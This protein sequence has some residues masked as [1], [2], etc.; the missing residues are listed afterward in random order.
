MVGS[1]ASGIGLALPPGLETA[2]HEPA[3]CGKVVP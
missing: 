2:V 1:I 3:F